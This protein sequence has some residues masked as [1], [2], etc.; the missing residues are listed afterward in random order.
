LEGGFTAETSAKGVP[1][2]GGLTR[3]NCVAAVIA[4]ASERNLRNDY[5][6]V[7]AQKQSKANNAV[8]KYGFGCMRA[9]DV[10][11]LYDNTVFGT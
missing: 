2:S 1:V 7:G 8:Q 3:E 4:F 5:V 11:V 10:L 6:F 9:E